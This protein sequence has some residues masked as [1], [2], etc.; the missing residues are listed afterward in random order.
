M[1]F[2]FPIRHPLI[3][4]NSGAREEYAVPVSYQTP[5]D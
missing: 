4:V 2:L 3:N 5:I 1:Q